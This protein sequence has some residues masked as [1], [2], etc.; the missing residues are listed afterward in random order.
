MQ[1]GKS[2]EFNPLDILATAAVLQRVD[3]KGNKVTSMTQQNSDTDNE[4]QSDQTT[5]GQN[6]NTKPPGNG[7][8]KLKVMF[9]SQLD[10]MLDEHNYGN[11]RKQKL[12]TT[13][14]TDVS[15]QGKDRK[16]IVTLVDK[17]GDHHVL[18]TIQAVKYLSD[19]SE[20]NISDSNVNKSLVNSEGS[21]GPKDSI[22]PSLDVNESSLNIDGAPEGSS[23]Q[24]ST[25]TQLNEINKFTD[26]QTSKQDLPEASSHTELLKKNELKNKNLQSD[27]TCDDQEDKDS[28]THQSDLTK[29]NNIIIDNK[30]D[31]SCDNGHVR[32]ISKLSSSEQDVLSLPDN[33]QQQPLPQTYVINISHQGGVLSSQLDK[34]CQQKGDNSHGTLLSPDIPEVKHHIIRT[35]LTTSSQN[36]GVLNNNIGEENPESRETED[37][38]CTCSCE[39]N[40]DCKN[41]KETDSELSGKMCFTDSI[42]INSQTKESTTETTDYHNREVSGGK[43]MD[44][45]DLLNV[46]RN[47]LIT[48]ESTSGSGISDQNKKLKQINAGISNTTVE[49]DTIKDCETNSQLVHSQSGTGLQGD[50]CENCSSE[51]KVELRNPVHP[52]VDHC[53]AGVLNKPS[54]HS[55]VPV[56]NMDDSSLDGIGYDD[57]ESPH[58]AISDLSQDSGFSDSGHSPDVDSESHKFVHSQYLNK[59]RESP[60]SSSHLFL[61]D[62]KKPVAILEIPPPAIHTSPKVGKYRIGTFASVSNS[63]MGLESPK[64]KSQLLSRLKTN[65]KR[66]ASLLTSPVYSSSLLSDNVELYN[67]HQVPNTGE[68][69][70]VPGTPVM[71]SDI[72]HD[73]DYCLPWDNHA[74]TV[75]NSPSSKLLKDASCRDGLN[76]KQK[77]KKSESSEK[78]RRMSSASSDKDYIGSMDDTDLSSP[79][80]LI[81]SP[82]PSTIP[83]SLLQQNTRHRVKLEKLAEYVKTG[84]SESKLKITGSFQDDYIYF[85]NTKSRSRRRTSHDIKPPV[86]S[87][88]I[89]IPSPKPGDI[90][91]PHLTDA[92]LEAI[93]QRRNVPKKSAH[94]QSPTVENQF[95]PPQPPVSLGQTTSTTLPPV[96]SSEV[97]TEGNGDDV[98][99]NIID[100]ILS[101][102]S[103]EPS[104]YSGSDAAPAVETSNFG[105]NFV[106]GFSPEQMN[107]TP[108]QME[109]LYSAMDQVSETEI[110]SSGNGGDEVRT[111]L[112]G[113]S[114]VTDSSSSESSKGDTPGVSVDDK[115]I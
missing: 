8:H 86:P 59:Q 84:N 74:S 79:D 50:N 45:S 66:P 29:C 104:S 30:T 9:T 33:S 111:T 31:N 107:L 10:K 41:S 68:K 39:N 114:K 90:V 2:V 40:C 20:N 89:L 24:N 101:L 72:E 15:P 44:V 34:K 55:M 88:K 13:L 91:V 26:Q 93:K 32:M 38:N 87:D 65:R 102:E 14:N 52:G 69:Y 115:G 92:D 61:S 103:G 46:D 98:S 97:R 78:R 56:D 82:L 113:G 7:I 11:A 51:K 43:S 81:G 21:L 22:T 64:S 100:T 47:K 23:S 96:S 18:K 76:N 106:M 75:A 109:I 85:L 27:L 3:S 94:L 28:L 99:K 1:E 105:D 110:K 58:S 48:S 77:D 60:P 112:S 71:K 54:N 49:N 35:L 53:Y 6:T 63:T 36:K 16:V 57:S 5:G 67:Q 80:S 4:D 12:C 37:N 17:S 19:K 42:E 83:Q 95:L 108:E 25:D 70:S 73:H 62:S